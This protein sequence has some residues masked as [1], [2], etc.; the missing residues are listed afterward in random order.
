[1]TNEER[2][3]LFNEATALLEKLDGHMTTEQN[4]NAANLIEARGHTDAA[5]RAV[6]RVKPD[7]T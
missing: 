4:A 2:L 5:R 7:V 1:M 3:E 6:A